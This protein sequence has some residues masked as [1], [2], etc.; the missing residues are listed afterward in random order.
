M[1]HFLSG[2]GSFLIGVFDQ[3]AAGMAPAVQGSRP[4]ATEFSGGG[5]YV[6]P[7]F[8][9]THEHVYTKSPTFDG[10]GAESRKPDDDEDEDDEE[11]EEEEDDE[12]EDAEEAEVVWRRPDEFYSG[13]Q[14]RLFEG[15]IEPNDINQGALGNCWYLCSIGK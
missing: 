5:K 15:K 1:S 14:F 13:K 2:A 11:E 10:E 4:A 8:A 12:E 6:D 7:Q 3:H 9:A